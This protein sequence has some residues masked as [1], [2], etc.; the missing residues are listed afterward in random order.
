MKKCIFFVL[1]PILAACGKKVTKSYQDM[2]GV[3][4]SSSN[5]VNYT[6]NIGSDN[7]GTYSEC[8]GLL[9]CTE[10]SGQAKVNDGY[11]KLGFKKFKIDTYPVQA[12][13][14]WYMKIDGITY[15]K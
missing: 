9:S 8:S 14:H 12:A 10:Y 11:L 3:W 5:N 4:S 6:I 15:Y 2:V 7:S 1:I 13:G